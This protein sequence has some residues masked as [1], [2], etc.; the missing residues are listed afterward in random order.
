MTILLAT[1]AT[2]LGLIL[3]ASPGDTVEYGPGVYPTL[4]LR[5]LKA[6]PGITLR[7]QQGADVTLGAVRIYGAAANATTGAPATYSGGYAFSGFTQYVADVKYAWEVRYCERVH[8]DDCAISGPVVAQTGLN[9]LWQ[10]VLAVN[11]RDFRVTNSEF[12]HMRIGVGFG[13]ANGVEIVGNQIHDIAG[14]GIRGCASN[15][16]IAD[17]EGWNFW[18]WDTAHFDFIQFSTTV[19]WSGG[20]TSKNITIENNVYRRG[21]GTPTTQFIF[22]RGDTAPGFGF[23]NVV[24]RNNGA[25]GL[26]HNGIA[27]NCIENATIEN[28]FVQA[29]A[30]SNLPWISLK[31]STGTLAVRNNVSASVVQVARNTP[32]AVVEGNEVLATPLAVG[33]YSSLDA[34]LASIGSPPE[35]PPP[36][37]DPTPEEPA[38]LPTLDDR[39]LVVESQQRAMAASEADRVAELGALAARVHELEAWTQRVI[40]AVA[41]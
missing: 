38:P 28:N 40:L 35:S 21:L 37:P 25:V 22:M 2:V 20:V 33:D 12:S 9:T 14:D 10:G 39:V 15:I 27:V 6:E 1:P 26:N 18:K 8:I 17:N 34:F 19:G 32:A 36:E 31:D 41:P 23:E 29:D 30:E 3:A 13:L 4:T 11:I 7:P 5:A 24:I 16:R